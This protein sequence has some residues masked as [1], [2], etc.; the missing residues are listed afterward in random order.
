MDANSDGSVTMDEWRDF[1]ISMKAELGDAGFRRAVARM[2]YDSDVSVEDIYVQRIEGL[3]D[4]KRKRAIASLETKEIAQVLWDV[5][6][7]SAGGTLRKHEI[8]YSPL[9][10]VLMSHWS[11]LDSTPDGKVTMSEFEQYLEK[12]KAKNPSAYKPWL[13]DLIY[14][15]GAAGDAFEILTRRM[16]TDATEKRM[17]LAKIAVCEP[18]YM[19]ARMWNT[20]DV[21]GNSELSKRE[22]ESSVFGDMLTGHWHELDADTNGNVSL[23]E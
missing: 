7:T 23:S 22:I 16:A 5:M 21:N 8:Q 15:A 4:V 20:L 11:E 18:K 1:F 6:D 10:E 19:L 2:V 17:E 14:D 12:V 9:G 3:T 13:V